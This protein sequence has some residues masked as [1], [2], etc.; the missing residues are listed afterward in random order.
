MLSVRNGLLVVVMLISNHKSL[1][2][3]LVAGGVTAV[4]RKCLTLSRAE[5]MLA[6]IALNHISMVH[7][8]ESKGGSVTELLVHFR[9]LPPVD[10]TQK[11]YKVYKVKYDPSDN[12]VNFT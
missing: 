3:Q 8:L 2:E 1:A 4:L 12:L 5:T 7:K 11:L 6:I 10:F 9:T